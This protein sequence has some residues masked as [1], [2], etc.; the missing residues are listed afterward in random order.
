MAIG[1]LASVAISQIILY[2]TCFGEKE[3][4]LVYILNNPP[5]EVFSLPLSNCQIGN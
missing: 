1:I 2:V 5:I 3:K 4:S